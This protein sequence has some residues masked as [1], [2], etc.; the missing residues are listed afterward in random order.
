MPHGLQLLS[1]PTRDQTCTPCSGSTEPSPV[2][3]QGSP[4]KQVLVK[5]S[6][7]I[8]TNNS[9]LK[10]TLIIFHSHQS[11]KLSLLSWSMTSRLLHPE[12]KPSSQL[13]RLSAAVETV[14]HSLLETFSSFYFQ[15]TTFPNY[16]PTSWAI[17][18]Q[19]PLLIPLISLT[20]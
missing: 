4:S 18:S 9:V 15:D 13:I 17:P 16:P 20:S 14:D 8:M 7:K 5:Q 3:R 12:V 19:T 6:F 1:S 2:G 11:T 10:P